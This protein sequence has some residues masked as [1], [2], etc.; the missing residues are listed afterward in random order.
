[1]PGYAEIT[2]PVLAEE[3]A[4]RAGVR[5]KYQMDPLQQYGACHPQ[6]RWTECDARIQLPHDGR[7]ANPLIASP[8]RRPSRRSTTICVLRCVRQT[9]RAVSRFLR[10]GFDGWRLRACLSAQ[11]EVTPDWR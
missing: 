11:P 2:S 3:E 1:M 7:M 6:Y 10:Q 8:S 5:R 4:K 9:G